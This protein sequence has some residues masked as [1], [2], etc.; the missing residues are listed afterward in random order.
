MSEE[1]RPTPQSVLRGNL[2]PLL[3]TDQ[4]VQNLMVTPMNGRG[5]LGPT[6]DNNFIVETQEG[7]KDKRKKLSIW[8]N[9]SGITSD[10]RLANYKK[11][12]EPYA[13][14]CVKMQLFCAD[15]GLWKAS[16]TANAMLVG[17]TEPGLGREMALR[18]NLNE[19][20][21]KN[22]SVIVENK[23]DDKKFLGGI[24]GGK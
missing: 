23:P 14:F 12:Q 24:F 9:R 3:E 6:L 22:D 2:S 13:R 8:D 11:T 10:V 18:N 21:Q 1:K 7:D 15:A 16:A 19:I 5:T 20:R 4:D 17:I